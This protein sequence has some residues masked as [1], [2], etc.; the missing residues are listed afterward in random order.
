[1]PTAYHV[2]HR[3]SGQ[4]SNVHNA[5]DNSLAPLRQ[6]DSGD[7][8]RFECPV[9]F[10][11]QVDLETTAE[12]FHENFEATGHNLV[13]PV[14]IR[15]AEP[16]DVLEV[17]L[18][19][20]QHGGWGHTFFRPGSEGLG[21]LPDDF[22]APGL[23]IWD[24]DGE[25]GRFVDGIEIPLDPFPGNLGVAPAEGGEHS[26]VPPRP[27]GGNLDIK[28]LTEGSTAYF[29]V[30][31]EEALFSIGDG[32]A[33]QGDGE[34]CLS[35]IE[36]PMYVTARLTVQSDRSVDRPQFRAAPRSQALAADPTYVT[37]GIG[38]DLYEAAKTAIRDMIDHLTDRR[39]LS[40]HDAYVL[41][42][43]AVDLRISEIVNRPNW[44][45][46]A[47]LPEGIFPDGDDSKDQS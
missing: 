47:H 39:G 38:G 40:R 43:V 20:V 1:M 30:E 6:I 16:G 2:D 9:G 12:E 46:S 45:V 27:M 18:L 8:V 37:T 32:H 3:I 13:G 35:A 21:L 29:P 31:V 10:E 36:T 25:V 7:V 33:A 34:V 5:W 15:G 26:T 19:E 11:G 24:L 22:D 23:H 4:S 41:C 17:E 14:A 28:Q 44:V 42:S